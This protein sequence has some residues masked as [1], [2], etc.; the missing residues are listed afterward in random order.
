MHY[1]TAAN[2]GYYEF[3]KIAIDNFNKKFTTDDLHILCMDELIHSKVT[4]L[5]ADSKNIY[6]YLDNQNISQFQSFNSSLFFQISKMKFNFIIQMMERLEGMFYFFDADVFFFKN[7]TEY[8]ENVVKDFDILFQQDSPVRDGQEIGGTYVCTG[9]F[10]IRKTQESMTL[11]KK[12]SSLFQRYPNKNDQE[13]LYEYLQ[14]ECEKNVVWNYKNAKL[15]IL[16]PHLFQNGYNGIKEEWYK[17][18]DSFCVHANHMIG[19]DN[20]KRAFELFKNHALI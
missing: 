7:P 6:L 5:I 3:I 13:I 19:K 8:L 10:C 15:G 1:L 4:E 12:I 9:N 14:R 2:D 11:L 20:K 18:Y 17:K 16:D